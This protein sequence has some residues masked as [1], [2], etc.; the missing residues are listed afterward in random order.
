MVAQST[1][2]GLLTRSLG[3]PQPSCSVGMGV[4]CTL[5]F[6]RAVLHLKSTHI[7]T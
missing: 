5:V 3:D 1:K 6:S 7:Y 2:K 4:T